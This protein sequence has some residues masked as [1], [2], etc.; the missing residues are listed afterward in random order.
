[1]TVKKNET[2][3]KEADVVFTFATAAP[4]EM[5]IVSCFYNSDQSNHYCLPVQKAWFP[6]LFSLRWR[7]SNFIYIEDL[8]FI[9]PLKYKKYVFMHIYVKKRM[10]YFKATIRFENWKTLRTVFKCYLIFH[11]KFG[12]EN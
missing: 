9:S 1:M 4:K 11:K 6:R 3:T 7:R 12:N 8:L 10:I 2:R 5:A